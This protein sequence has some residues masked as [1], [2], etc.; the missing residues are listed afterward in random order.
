MNVW[1]QQSQKTDK[2]KTFGH[3]DAFGHKDNFVVEETAASSI[4]KEE[5][6]FNINLLAWESWR[7]EHYIR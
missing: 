5:E 4:L 1:K 6:P 2:S 7:P 3:T